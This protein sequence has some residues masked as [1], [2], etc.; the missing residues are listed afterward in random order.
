MVD[1]QETVP[2]LELNAVV[3]L[4]NEVSP[5]LRILQVS[6]DGWDLPTFVPGQ[7]TT[8]GCTTPRLVAD[9]LIRKAIRPSRES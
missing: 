6:P 1:R 4:S 2:K 8:L 9:L 3:T 7:Y 5:W